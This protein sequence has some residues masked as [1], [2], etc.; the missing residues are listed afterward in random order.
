MAAAEA[1]DAAIIRRFGPTN[2]PAG[3]VRRVRKGPIVAPVGAGSDTRAL[4][5][6]ELP[7]GRE[8]CHAG[9]EVERGKA[10]WHPQKP[11]ARAAGAERTD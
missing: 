3:P 6:M 1:G 5:E 9:V 2:N 4:V 10:R 7:V 11:I 8:L